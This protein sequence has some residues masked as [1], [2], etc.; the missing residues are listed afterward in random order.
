M[1]ELHMAYS[2][3]KG[4]CM[5]FLLLFLSITLD[6]FLHFCTVAVGFLLYQY[7][8]N[9][10]RHKSCGKLIH[11]DKHLNHICFPL[12]VTLSL[13]ANADGSRY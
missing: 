10:Q 12:K 11:N 7:E 5:H 6:S 1:L 8:I 4:A 9:L 2:K 13:C 3:L